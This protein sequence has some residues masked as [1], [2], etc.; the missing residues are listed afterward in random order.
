MLAYVPLRLM[1]LSLFD[2]CK[3]KLIH[4]FILVY[5]LIIMKVTLGKIIFIGK[6]IKCTT[7]IIK[8]N[9]IKRKVHL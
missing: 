6:L 9:V 3:I 7:I 8:F 1:L 2:A 4:Y 5:S